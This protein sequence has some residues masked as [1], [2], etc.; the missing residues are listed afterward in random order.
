ML[1]QDLLNMDDERIDRSVDCK[2]RGVDDRQVQRIRLPPQI[3][4]P[5]VHPRIR[6]LG[7]PPQPGEPR[8]ADWGRAVQQ[9]DSHSGCAGPLTSAADE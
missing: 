8:M 7:L 3:R 9:D 1:G 2:V 4:C 6:K 5:T